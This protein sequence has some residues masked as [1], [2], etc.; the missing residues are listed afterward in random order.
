M[1]GVNINE[2]ITKGLDRG[3]RNGRI[4]DEGARLAGCAQLA[5]EQAGGGIVF[6]IVFLKKLLEAIGRD[7]K[8]GLDNALIG[9]CAGAFCISTTAQDE[10]EGAEN[11]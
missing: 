11:D 4:I 6:K 8:F 2:M 9:P 1:L 10:C 7:V 3:Q 5:T